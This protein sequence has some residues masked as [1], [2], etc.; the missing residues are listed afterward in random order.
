MLIIYFNEYNWNTNQML[1]DVRDELMT[2]G[3]SAAGS[4]PSSKGHMLLKLLHTFGQQFSDALDGRNAGAA[5]MLTELYGGA[6]ISFIFNEIFGKKLKELDPFEGL[7]DEDI[8]TAIRNATGPRPA[9]FVPE[10]AFEILAKR[11]I[12]LLEPLGLQVRFV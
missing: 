2:L 6:R 9:L 5:E 11:Q 3:S 12:G 7:S 10:A 1:R 8:R 4:D